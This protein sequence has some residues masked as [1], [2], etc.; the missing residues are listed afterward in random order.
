MTGLIV[1]SITGGAIIIM[2]IVLLT[3]RGGFLLAGY[4][5]MPKN[6]KAKYNTPAL[7]KFMGKIFLPLGVIVILWGIEA[8]Y[9][10]WFW[11]TGV[12]FGGLII[13][14]IVYANTGNR[15]RN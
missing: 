2:S 5:T 15:F 7:C 13:F 1:C 4:N 10:S 3:G 14:A 12:I 11:I 6:E 8:L 9:T